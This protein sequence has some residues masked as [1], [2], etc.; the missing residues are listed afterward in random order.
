V[1]PASLF[2]GLVFASLGF[3]SW[4]VGRRRS[5]ARRLILGAVLVGLPLVLDGWAVWAVGGALGVFVFWP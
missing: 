1:D 3:Y 4:Q 5:D 2:A